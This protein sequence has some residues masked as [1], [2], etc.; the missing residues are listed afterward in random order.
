MLCTIVRGGMPPPPPPPHPPLHSTLIGCPGVML[1]AYSKT[2]QAELLAEERRVLIFY[3][4][5]A[6]CLEQC[7]EF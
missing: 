6:S 2:R 5:A 3:F 7:N 1:G 4:A